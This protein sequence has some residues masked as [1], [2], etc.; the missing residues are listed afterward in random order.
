MFT[1]RI[2]QELQLK[3]WQK[4]DAQ[5]LFELMEESREHIRTFL[6]FTDST[7]EV[8]DTEKFIETALRSYAENSAYHMGILFNREL[9][10]TMSLHDIDMNNKSA[11]IGYWISKNYEGKGIIS[12]TC[13]G[14]LDAAFHELGLNRVQIQA[15]TSNNRSRAVP[16]RLGFKQ[17]GIIR[18]K[19]YL[20]GKFEDHALYGIL[21]EDWVSN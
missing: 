18:Q 19:E 13:K 6:G 2:D 5:R 3:L 12:R 17:E 8:S 21:K 14:L 15:V 4:Q 20:H 16:E 9:V 11:E 10:G 1:Y 7:K